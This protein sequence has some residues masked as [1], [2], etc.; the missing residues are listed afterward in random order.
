MRIEL[1]SDNIAKTLKNFD[2]HKIQGFKEFSLKKTPV[3]IR[4]F[5]TE[6]LRYFENHSIFGCN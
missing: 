5:T 3:I 4:S 2:A 1:G 6:N